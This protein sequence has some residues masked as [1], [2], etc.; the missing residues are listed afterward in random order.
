MKDPIAYNQVETFL[1][2]RWPKKIHLG[3]KHILNSLLLP[4]TFRQSQGIDTQV[5][6][7][8]GPPMPHA[9]V[10]TQLASTASDIEHGG[11]IWDLL[12]QEPGEYSALSHLSETESG[13]DV[14]VIRERVLFVKCLYDVLY[15]WF[16]IPIVGA[17]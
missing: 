15:V 8:N 14:L 6:P 2:Q 9:E 3:E 12:I 1:A 13:I 17:K 4:E 10:V 5:G 16:A 11:T 7:E